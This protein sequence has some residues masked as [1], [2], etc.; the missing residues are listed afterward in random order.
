MMGGR[1][2]LESEIARGTTFHF[3]APLKTLAS[4]VAPE[5][6]I[7]ANALR[8]V[9]ALIV[10]DNATNRKILCGMLASWNIRVDEAEDGT[11]ALRDLVSAQRVGDP[12]RLLLS[13]VH[14]PD[15]SGFELVEQVRRDPALVNTAIM[16]L[17]S[18]GQVGDAERSLRLCIASSL[19]KPVRKRELLAS[20]EKALGARHESSPAF[21]VERGSPSAAGSPLHI[22]LAEDNRVN[23][24]VATRTLEKMG[25]SIVLAENGKS[26]L[27]RL[28]AETFDLVLMD[29]QMPEMDG[30]TATRNIRKQEQGTEAHL[31]IIA[32]TAHTMKGDRERCLEGGMDG[33]VSKP[34]NV[35][36][37]QDA[38]WLA[39]KS[40]R[41]TRSAIPGPGEAEAIP[42]REPNR[43]NMSETL[44]RLGGDESLLHD[45][46]VIFHEEAPKKIAALREALAQ[47][48]ADSLGKTAHS[49]K[50]ELGYL[51]ASQ[52]SQMARE[53]EEMGRT[54][55]LHRAPAVFR[56]L[57]RA[58][59][60]LLVSMH[61][62]V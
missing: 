17:T 54:Q 55:D 39:M 34:F 27:S 3:T 59:E 13:D 58:I 18:A 22:L 40:R 1:I 15:M 46:V 7:S 49:L 11:R 60:A 24:I 19:I 51:G 53:L 29:L 45:V 26:A 30:L 41:P 21:A 28:A 47:G 32:M 36:E 9:R 16:M 44:R 61:L 23:Q 12:Y 48:D 8:E 20:I 2:W 37:L 56:A 25:H 31:P 43:W 62:G 57:E 52:L 10:D 6:S 5:V 35:K 38:I 50:G 14:M 33:Y 4:Q 42:A